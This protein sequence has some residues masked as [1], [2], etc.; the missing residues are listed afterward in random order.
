MASA[1]LLKTVEGLLGEKM[2]EEA[3]GLHLC[4]YSGVLT[5]CSQL[6]LHTIVPVGPMPAR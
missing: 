4:R 3:V 6:L 1:F 5:Q 2:G